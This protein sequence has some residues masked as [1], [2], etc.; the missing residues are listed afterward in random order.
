LPTVLD[1][2]K[3]ATGMG[4]MIANAELLPDHL[5][6]SRGR[7][8]LPSKPE[9]LRSLSQ[10]VRQLRH[11]FRTQLCFPAGR[12]LMPQG[13]DSLCFR[14]LEPLT[15]LFPRSLRVR[16]Q[17]LSVSILVHAIPRRVSVVLRANF[18]EV[19]ISCSYLLPSAFRFNSLL[20]SAQINKRPRC[21][22]PG[23]FAMVSNYL[24]SED[25]PLLDYS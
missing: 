9:G 3:E 14:F 6:D 5:Y 15:R 4:T 25:V 22:S 16:P 21:Q 23:P 19:S 1:A 17:C 2:T 20:F 10:Q 13:F 7:P 8:D 18:A 24:I 11:L 12:R